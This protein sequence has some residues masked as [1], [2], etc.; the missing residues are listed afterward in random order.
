MGWGEAIAWVGSIP[1]LVPAC[2]LI[3]LTWAAWRAQRSGRARTL[4]RSKPRRRFSVIVPAH[5]EERLLGSTLDSLLGLDYPADLYDIHVVADHCTD[6][7]A[8]IARTRGVYAHERGDPE[9][10][11]KGASLRWLLDRLLASETAPDAV[12]V[13]D[14]DTTVSPN[15]LRVMDARLSDRTPV[16]QAYYAARNDET[17]SLIGFRAAALAARHY[18]RPLGRTAL[19]CSSG[20]YGNGMAFTTEVAR[21]HAWSDHLTEDLE[22]QLE[23]LLAGIRVGF[24]ADAVVEA[25]MPATLEAS[26]S[27]HE[28]WERGRSDVARRYLPRLVTRAVRGGPPDR[29]ACV[30]A[31]LDQ[32]MPPVSVVLA[33]TA[34]WAGASMVAAPLL[35]SRAA[36]RHRRAAVLVATA[37][38]AHVLSSL[39]M[40]GASA[41]V[42]RSLLRT[43]QMLAWKARLWVRVLT[44]ERDAVRW[45]RTQRND[46]AS[47]AA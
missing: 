24:A 8:T 25:E 30:D 37:I 26:R 18:L 40:V 45:V 34:V 19:G 16:V 20:L 9:P 2:Y 29:V 22:L 41:S 10:A 47:A 33:G 32:L 7:T 44:K 27:Q 1:L 39:R 35:K 31:T 3:V 13:I 5:D 46:S 17:S 21:S 14:A 36:T 43:P 4:L 38:A 28:R 42:Y 23:L 12:A 6:A 15:F 11:G